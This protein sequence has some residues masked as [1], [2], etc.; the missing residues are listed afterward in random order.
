MNTTIEIISKKKNIPFDFWK[1]PKVS[2]MY[3]NSLI[4][5]DNM[6]NYLIQ[7]I[8]QNESTLLSSGYLVS[9]RG[10]IYAV[11]CYHGV[12]DCYE[13]STNLNKTKLKLN[14][15]FEIADFDM[16]ILT[17]EKDINETT[18]IIKNYNII[19]I[20]SI[21][22]EIPDINNNIKLNNMKSKIIN[23][24][25]GQNGNELF[26]TIPQICIE[27]P[28]ELEK[29]KVFGVSGSPCFLK[30]KYIGQVFSYNLVKDLI[31]IIP[32]YCLKYAFM[33]MLPNKIHFL[34]SLLI[35]GDL[36][37]IKDD[38]EKLISAYK[39]NKSNQIEYNIFEEDKKFTLKKNMI[40]YE[41]DKNEF[42]TDGNIFFKDMNIFVSPCVYILLNNHKKYFEIKGYEFSSGNYDKFNVIIE[43]I[44]LINNM[45]FTIN[46]HKKIIIYKNSCN[47]II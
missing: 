16:A 14:L 24:C 17:F 32:A 29:S 27:R 12:K 25:E 6:D 46:G 3:E 7:E 4:H 43:P 10:N 34:K 5:F 2:S 47:L 45:I 22:T 28:I 39:I 44:N 23:Y 36:C 18:E 20:F 19:D 42:N 38:G 21:A 9:Y 26:T 11:T 35:D 37:K 13:F 40:I 8:Y 30:K 33:F 31:N 41:I 1:N 15:Y